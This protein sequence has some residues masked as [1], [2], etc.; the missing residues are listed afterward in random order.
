M[1]YADVDHADGELLGQV[2]LNQME[3]NAATV[4][5]AT[6]ARL[7]VQVLTDWDFVDDGGTLAIT[8]GATTVLS[9]GPFSASFSELDVDITGEADGLLVIQAGHVKHRFWKTPDTDLVSVWL[10]LVLVNDNL[11]FT[12]IRHFNVTIVAHRLPRGGY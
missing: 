10:E 7:A 2:K 4:R 9:T 1:A 12:Q 8:V 5:A 3:E 6:D 11:P